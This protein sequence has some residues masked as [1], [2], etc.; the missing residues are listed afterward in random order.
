MVA[1]PLDQRPVRL[2]DIIGAVGATEYVDVAVH[3]QAA[4]TVWRVLRD[5]RF[6]LRDGRFETALARLL[7]ALL[8]MKPL[9]DY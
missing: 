6:V 4:A 7:N 3:L 8:R 5:G 1:N 9:K 2:A